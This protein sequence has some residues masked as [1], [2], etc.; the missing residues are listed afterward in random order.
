[1]TSLLAAR[2]STFRRAAWIIVIRESFADLGRYPPL[3][4]EVVV[5]HE[6]RPSDQRNHLPL[7]LLGPSWFE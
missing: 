3:L 5:P 4:A 6:E 7:I 1:M 2:R